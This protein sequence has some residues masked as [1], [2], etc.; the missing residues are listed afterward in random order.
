MRASPFSSGGPPGARRTALTIVMVAASVFASGCTGP[1]SGPDKI[2]EGELQGAVA[3]AGAGAVTGFQV[4]AG[5]GPGALVGAG[6]GAV[7]GGIRG[8]A[9]DLGEESL[10]ELSAET[11]QERERAYAQEILSEHYE[12]RLQLH[13]TRDIYPADLFF[14]GDDVKLRPEARVLVREIARINANRLP[15]SRLAITV[16]SKAANGE[17]NDY[18][19]K[20]TERRSEALSNEL[21]R[22]G[23]EPRRLEPRAVL[24]DAPLLIDPADDP[25]RY[26]Q[27]V[28]IVPLDR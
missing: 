25:A 21:V 11:K 15:W 5:T 12:R 19:V 9:Q 2:F 26:N 17:P 20:L 27:A 16:Y 7:A 14:C 3:G 8:L 22:A 23:I 28:E 10:L 1:V 4:G 24:V 13:P 18:A 6:L